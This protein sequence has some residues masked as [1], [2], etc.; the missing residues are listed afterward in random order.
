MVYRSCKSILSL[1]EKV[2]ARRLVAA[3]ACATEKLAYGYQDIHLI[4]QNG[5]ETAYMN[6]EDE[7]TNTDISPIHHNNIRGSQYYSK[8]NN[9]NSEK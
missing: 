1:L 4:L 5:E 8:S 3:Y 7:T 9:A 6:T 2:G